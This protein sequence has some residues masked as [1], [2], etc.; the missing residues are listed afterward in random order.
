[1][2]AVARRVGQAFQ[3]GTKIV[4]PSEDG[5]PS[6][7]Y[8]LVEPVGKG[9]YGMVY[10]AMKMSTKDYF[11][12]KILDLDE[13]A[14]AKGKH[15]TV[16]TAAREVAAH[17]ML[18]HPNVIKYYTAF[19]HQKYLIIVM[20]LADQGSLRQYVRHFGV[21]SEEVIAYVMKQAL[22]GIAFM[23]QNDMIHRDIKAANFLLNEQCDVKLADFGLSIGNTA[24]DK[25]MSMVG[26]PYWM[27]PEVIS[28]GT[29]TK[30][31]DIWSLGITA[32]EMAIGDPP[33]AEKN[34][35]KVLF[36]IA[37]PEV[38]SP[39]LPKEFFPDGPFQDFLYACLNK[40]P[41]QR[42]S[43]VELLQMPFIKNAR[44]FGSF[45][46]FD[47]H[48]RKTHA[49]FKGTDFE[50]WFLQRREEIKSKRGPGH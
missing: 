11:A 3:K 30:A 19:V 23:H 36:L 26:T 32:I 29:Q 50:K 27:A 38:P 17:K 40:D 25:A 10:R 15:S 35:T 49:S 42:K 7:E 2:D 44:D 21:L 9:A 1:M 39:T 48:L 31:S 24:Q 14:V 45:E 8:V 18:S 37:P 20:E 5:E 13:E 22:T 4:S 12:V 47:D 34:P 28:H 46:E 33:Y 41:K 16:E 43:A 6:E